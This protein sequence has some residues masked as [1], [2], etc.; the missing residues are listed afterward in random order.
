[1]AWVDWYTQFKIVR[2]NK[3][4]L[5]YILAI[6]AIVFV[7]MY[8]PNSKRLEQF[9]NGVTPQKGEPCC[10]NTDYMA[11]HRV[12]CQAPHYQGVQFANP[13]YGCPERHPKVWDG[14]II[15]R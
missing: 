6:I 9:M 7:M 5:I 13:D 1:M 4:Q 10:N 11:T 2:N 12:Q 14:A 8:N 15:G 3:M